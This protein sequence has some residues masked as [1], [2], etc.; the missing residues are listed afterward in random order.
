MT[1]QEYKKH[2]TEKANKV[3]T[4]DDLIKLIDE[5]TSYKHDY[6]T[7]VY[8]L[9]GAMKGAFKVVNDSEQGGITGF[10]A[11]C[12]GWELIKEFFTIDE[13]APAK[14]FKYEDFLYPQYEDRFEKAMPKTSWEWIQKKA[15]ENILKANNESVHPKVLDHWKSIAS[16]NVPFGFSVRDEV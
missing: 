15:Q 3:K 9:F 4:K 12:L 11:S 7:I 2:I 14:L 5:I 10:Q 16:G 13:N 6:G 1:E 8:G